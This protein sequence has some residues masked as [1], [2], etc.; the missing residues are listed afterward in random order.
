MGLSVSVLSHERI[1]HLKMIQGVVNRIAG[2]STQT[3]TWAASLVTAAFVFS[4][5]ADDPDWLVG[6]GACISVMAFWAMDARYV[7]LER[8]YRNLYSDAVAESVPLFDLDHRPY[9]RSTD[10]VWWIG[11]SW[12]IRWFYGLLLVMAFGLL[13]LL[14]T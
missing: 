6:A 5:A 1:E 7:H 10:S 8:C 4:G 2:N 12:S 13:I 3:K 14:A 11:L 9:V